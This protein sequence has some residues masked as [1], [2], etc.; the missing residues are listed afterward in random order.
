MSSLNR[1]CGTSW[2]EIRINSHQKTMS[3]L[4]GSS[5]MSRESITDGKEGEEEEMEEVDQVRDRKFPPSA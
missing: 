1:G 5:T 4:K 2:A 3:Q